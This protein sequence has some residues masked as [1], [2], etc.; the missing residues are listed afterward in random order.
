MTFVGAHWNTDSV[1]RGAAYVIYGKTDSDDVHLSDIANGRGGFKIIGQP[2]RDF[3]GNSV[4]GLG[5]VNNDGFADVIVGAPHSSGDG[6]AYVVFGKNDGASVLLDDISMGRGGF[7]ILGENGLLV[8]TSISLLSD[9]NG[10]GR[11]DILIG[12]FRGAGYVLSGFSNNSSPAVAPDNYTIS[13]DRQLV[14]DRREGVL[15]NDEDAQNDALSAH[16]MAGPQHGTLTLNADGS[17][18]YRPNANYVGADEFTY[19]ANDGLASSARVSVRIDVTSV[20]DSPTL[21]SDS[22]GRFVEKARR[23]GAPRSGVGSRWT[24]QFPLGQ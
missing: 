14:V 4:A 15:V 18:V 10:D 6:A 12:A 21:T 24:H 2:S 11:S 3:A 8:G 19:R 1:G 13:E 23:H 22:S 5:D 16:L 9:L 20:N 17:F 7:K